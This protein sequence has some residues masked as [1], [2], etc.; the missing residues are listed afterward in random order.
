MNN[1]KND[2]LRGI[3]D[4]NQHLLE[5]HMTMVDAEYEY[6]LHLMEREEDIRDE[7]EDEELPF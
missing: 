1:F 6:H 4:F 3:L 5:N 7:R 2:Y